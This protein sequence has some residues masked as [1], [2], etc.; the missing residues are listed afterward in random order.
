M[1]ACAIEAQDRAANPATL[2]T[3][4]SAALP[5][6]PQLRL[7]RGLPPLRVRRRQVHNARVAAIN[8]EPLLIADSVLRRDEHYFSILTTRRSFING[9]L[10]ALYRDNAGPGR[11][12]SLRR[13]PDTGVLPVVPYTAG[14]HRGPSTCAR[15]QPRACSPRPRSSTAS[16]PSARASTSSTR[17]SS[18]RPSCPPRTRACPPPEDA[19]NRENN[20]AK[21]CGCNYC[22]ATIEPTGAHWGR[23]GERNAQYLDSGSLPPLRR[24]VPRLR[25]RRQHHLRRRVRQ[26]RDAGLRRRRRQLAG[27]AQDLPVPHA[28]DEETNIEGGPQLLVQRM[29][30]TGDLERCAVK[31]HLERVPR[32]ADVGRK[33][34]LYLEP[35][36]E[37]SPTTTT[38]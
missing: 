18:A 23:Y 37:A 33:S 1:A 16:P 32:P 6:R 15:Q 17:R 14:R 30:Q 19:C 24:Q 36:V 5:G 11:L 8:E 13:P 27:H 25:A 22:H 26:L 2:E 12:H 38:T 9:P 28:A 4:E 29:L 31:P 7:R 10:S 35:L 21:R 34:S 3:C 20:L